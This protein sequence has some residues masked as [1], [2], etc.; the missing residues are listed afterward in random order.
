VIALSS[1]E[2]PSIK[3]DK[4]TFTA[5]VH[6]VPNGG[7]VQFMGTGGEPLSSCVPQR[8]NPQT[9][10]AACAMTISK[11]GAFEI[12]AAY[13]GTTSF[14]GSQSQ[15]LT[16]T[17]L[18]TP[19]AAVAPA[20]GPGGWAT[21]QVGTS[22]VVATVTTAP[23]SGGWDL[24]FSEESAA[25]TVVD[26]AGAKPRGH[27]VSVGSKRV[28]IPGGRRTRVTIKP[29]ATGRR[30]LRRFGKLPVTLTATLIVGGRRHVVATRK[31]TIRRAK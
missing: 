6:P 12:V 23:S 16:Q 20:A 28:R 8:G 13:S 31:L 26:I 2:N 25:N 3:G 30:L 17:V 11:S 1:S 10:E 7:T 21:T 5:T 24:S 15:T 4:V 29:N 9:G 18:E 22:N 14:T 19:R 27:A